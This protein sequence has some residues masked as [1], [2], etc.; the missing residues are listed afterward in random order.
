MS[1]CSLSERVHDQLL[2]ACSGERE[3]CGLLFGSSTAAGAN[4]RLLVE[5]PNRASRHDRFALDP[6]DVV[7]AHRDHESESARCVGVWHTHP[8]SDPE[9]SEADLAGAAEG[10]ISLIA[11]KGARLAAYRHRIGGGVEVLSVSVRAA[12]PK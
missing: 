9:L 1:S 12:R 10:W 11:G 2:A 6:A 5:L 4:V 7:R 8:E 3:R